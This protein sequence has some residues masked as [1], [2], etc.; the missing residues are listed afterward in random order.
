[1]QYH[2]TMNYLC[3]EVGEDLVHEV[4]PAIWEVSIHDA[5]CTFQQL[6]AYCRW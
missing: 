4:G 5:A 1:M 6:R 2:N 3:V